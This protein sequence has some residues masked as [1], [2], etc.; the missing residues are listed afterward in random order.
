MTKNPALH[1]LVVSGFYDLATPFFAATYTI[2]HLGLNPVVRG[3]ISQTFY[4]AGHM[5]YLNFPDL[6]KLKA[7]VA[8]FYARSL[9]DAGMGGGHGNG[10]NGSKG[11]GGTK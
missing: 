11:A 4:Q 1:V 2:D 3:H 5:V 10:G 8:A 9:A 6:E 7:D